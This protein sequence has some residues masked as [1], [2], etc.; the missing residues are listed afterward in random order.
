MPRADHFEFES[1]SDSD[2]VPDEDLEEEPVI[3]DSLDI[4][5][6]GLKKTCC[7]LHTQTPGKT[8]PS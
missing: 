3:G 6:S 4:L 1:E 5:L 2:A 7:S 8:S